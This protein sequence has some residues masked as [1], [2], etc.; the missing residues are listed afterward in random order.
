MDGRG[1]LDGPANIPA[2]RDIP[3]SLNQN[4]EKF[5]GHSHIQIILRPFVFVSES[6]FAES[7]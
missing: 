5:E 2:C 6:I 4:N 7:F 1:I 3:E